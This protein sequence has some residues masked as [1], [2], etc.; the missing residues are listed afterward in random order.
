VNVTR[1]DATPKTAAHWLE[2]HTALDL[3]NAVSIGDSPSYEPRMSCVGHPVA[4]GNAKQGTK[5]R[6]GIAL[7]TKSDITS[8]AAHVVILE[9][10]LRRVDEFIHISGRMRRIALQS[11]LGG[12]SLSTVGMIVA[13]CGLITPVVGAIAQEC[14]DVFAV[15]NALRAAQEPG[16][17]SHKL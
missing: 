2:L 9:P 12:M 1:K 7:G 15:L 13:A 8:E 5:E 11:A 17:K 4:M 6:A 14:I 3:K 16:E 10:S